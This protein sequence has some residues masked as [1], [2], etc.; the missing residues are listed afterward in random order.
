MGKG[1]HGARPRV[2]TLDEALAKLSGR[3]AG[4]VLLTFALISPQAQTEA[5]SPCTRNLF[6]ENTG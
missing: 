2:V 4:S 5:K 6:S 1:C 3:T